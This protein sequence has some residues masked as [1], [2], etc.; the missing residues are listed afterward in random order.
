[1]YELINEQDYLKSMPKFSQRA[2][3]KKL[4]FELD[5]IAFSEVELCMNKNKW[6]LGS[7]VSGNK[8]MLIKAAFNNSHDFVMPI[9]KGM[10]ENDKR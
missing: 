7:G 4:G 5:D 3:A 1:M 2:Y 8:D 9:I 6:D 10:I